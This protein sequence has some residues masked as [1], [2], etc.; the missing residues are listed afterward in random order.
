VYVLYISGRNMCVCVC[1][2]VFVCV[3]MC[4]YFK[5]CRL[6]YVDVHT[7]LCRLRYIPRPNGDAVGGIG[8]VPLVG[9]VR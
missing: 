5:L 4:V 2:C 7:S 6:R 3:C 8:V 1:V 9:F